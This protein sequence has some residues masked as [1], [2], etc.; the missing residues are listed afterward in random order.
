MLKI[1]VVVFVLVPLFELYVLIEVGSEIGALPT[2]LLTV[3]TALL[4]AWL[5]RHQGMQVMQD[6]QLAMANGEAPQQQ[7]IEGVLIFFGGAMLLLPG[8]VTDALGLILLVPPIRASLAQ[9][10]LRRM[11]RIRASR[12]PIVEG[13]WTVKTTVNE[14]IEYRP[15][16]D[17]VI[18]G[19]WIEP[20]KK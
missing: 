16:R 19:E 4:G 5:M 11:A 3:A 9:A 7:V 12:S 17:D 13:E 6:A 2:I 20:P 10:W 1:F 18:E 14:R 8:L 15:S